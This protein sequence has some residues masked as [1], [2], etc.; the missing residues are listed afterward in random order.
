M[1]QIVLLG[2]LAGL[3]NVQVAAAISLA[4]LTRGRRILFAVAFS[5]CEIASPLLGLLLM[6]SLRVRWGVW[7]DRSAPLIVVLCGLVILFLAFR[8]KDELQKLVNHR[9]TLV[10]LPI[11]LS[12][13]NLLIGI[14][15]GTLD[16]PLPLAA[17][18]IG[19]V[20]ATM[21]VLGIIGGARLRRWIPEYAEVVSGL[22]LLVIAATMWIEQ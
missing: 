1:L 12:F 15:L 11:S 6:G 17:A 22:Y 2:I 10:G 8:D 5:I 4:P 21:C 9:W 20:S 19:C 18:T 7:L 3:D 14:S 16:Y 13:D